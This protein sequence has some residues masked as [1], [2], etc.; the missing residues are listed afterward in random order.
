M[1]VGFQM[2]PFFY[3]KEEEDLFALCNYK[4]QDHVKL[5]ADSEQFVLEVGSNFPKLKIFLDASL[6]FTLLVGGVEL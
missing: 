6:R 5:N 1:K 2:H 4:T 3:H